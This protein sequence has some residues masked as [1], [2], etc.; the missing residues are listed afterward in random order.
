MPFA[1]FTPDLHVGH[2]EID[3]QHAAL[4]DTVNRLHEALRAGRSRQ[5]LGDILSFL[6]TYTVTHFHAEEALMEASSY[7]G[8]PAHRTLHHELAQQVKDLDIKYA[9]GSMTLSIMTMHFLR[10]WLSHHIQ[11]EDRKLADFLRPR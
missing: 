9:A 6:H 4:F 5:E 2:E 7:P 8:L 11:E 3:E 10:D 1:E